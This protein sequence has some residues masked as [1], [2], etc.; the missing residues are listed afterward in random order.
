MLIALEIKKYFYG[1]DV[2]S[3]NTKKVWIDL[4]FSLLSMKAIGSEKSGKEK[5]KININCVERTGDVCGAKSQ[6]YKQWLF[7]I[8]K[9]L[10]KVVDVI[11]PDF[12]N[13][14]H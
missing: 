10:L 4:F 14:D 6:F 13:T 7:Q 9:A 5:K 3:D 2:Q 8:K 12:H 1:A 11:H